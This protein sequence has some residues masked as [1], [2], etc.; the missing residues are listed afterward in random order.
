[1]I[2]NDLQVYDKHSR[3]L[4]AAMLLM[5]DTTSHS[6]ECD[7]IVESDVLYVM[8]H[9]YDI[10]VKPYHGLYKM[11]VF[12]WTNTVKSSHILCDVADVAKAIR[13]IHIYHDVYTYAY[14]YEY[15][16]GDNY[17]VSPILTM[18]GIHICIVD[19]N[20]FNTIAGIEFR[21]YSDG[22][23]VYSYH[24][25]GEYPVDSPAHILKDF[26]EGWA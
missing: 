13:N 6:Y 26:L 9:E 19:T 5:F 11:T 8:S 12:N 4:R 18:S 25:S 21:Y 2:I 16:L 1:M 7:V 17:I 15:Q 22:R 23:F 3:F 10:V 20:K 14:T 24:G